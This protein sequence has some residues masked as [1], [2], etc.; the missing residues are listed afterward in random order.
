MITNSSASSPI[1]RASPAAPRVLGRSS[2]ARRS[3]SDGASP[4]GWRSRFIS[5][6]LASDAV[7]A[8]G[9]RHGTP[10][11]LLPAGRRELPGGRPGADERSLRGGAAGGRGLGRAD[12]RAAALLVPDPA[13]GQVDLAAPVLG[14]DDAGSEGAVGIKPAARAL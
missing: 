8:I 14:R 12:R 9:S 11:V 10:L 1:R 7:G 6:N 4:A 2:G 5:P 3:G 13:G